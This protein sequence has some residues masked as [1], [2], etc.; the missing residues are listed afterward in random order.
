MKILYLITKDPD[1]ALT[2]ILDENKKS[3]ETTVI[4]LRSNT[5]YAEII[6]Q[7]EAFDKVIS[8]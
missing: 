1:P 8:W 7:I 2:A 4:D 6:D 3:H 5:Q